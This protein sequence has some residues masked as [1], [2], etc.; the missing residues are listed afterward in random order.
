M[1]DLD[2]QLEDATVAKKSWIPLTEYSSKHKVSVSTLRRRIKTSQVEYR[3]SAGKY[4]LLDTPL[5]DHQWTQGSSSSISIDDH[6]VTTAPPQS[7]QGHPDQEISL[8]KEESEMKVNEDPISLNEV[9]PEIKASTAS[10]AKSSVEDETSPIILT[11]NK[12]LGELKSAYALILQEKEEQ[13]VQLREEIADLK[14]LVRV[15]ESENHRLRHTSQLRFDNDVW[16][17]ELS[18]SD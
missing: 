6:R 13:I 3:Y 14:T 10:S 18:S 4:L 8:D 16:L 11:A 7:A 12:L 1:L 9:L 15:L 17:E 5:D 2:S